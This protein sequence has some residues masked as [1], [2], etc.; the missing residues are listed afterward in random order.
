MKTNTYKSRPLLWVTGLSGSGHSTALKC[1]EDLG[2]QA[3]DNL[4]LSM[5]ETLLDQKEGHDK[6][7]AIGIDARAWDFDAQ[8]VID[9]AK[10][11]AMRDDTDFTLVFLDCGD[12]VL[13]QRYTETRRRHPL[14]IDRPVADGIAAER[15]AVE[16]L[17]EVADIVIDTSDIKPADLRRIMTGHFQQEEDRGLFIYVTSFGF[18]NGVPRDADMVIDVRFLDNPYWNEALR[19]LSGLDKGVQAMIAA[20][21]GFDDF[22]ANL[23]KLIQPLLPRYEKEGKKYLTLA[24]GCT[25]G[26]HRSVFVAEKLHGWIAAQGYI[27]AVRHRDMD[28][29]AHLHK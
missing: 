17:K 21:P 24:M 19:P 7:L 4:P 3:I 15:Q 23:Q 16:P 26:R 28:I 22:I 25:G 29:W 5:V 8:R 20:D 12:D 27:G 6:P 2:Y 11:I 18:K 13:L 1:L 14:A 10:S 9:T